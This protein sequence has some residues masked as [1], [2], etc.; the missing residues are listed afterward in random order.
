MSNAP[1]PKEAISY[2]RSVVD[3]VAGL[4]VWFC[5]L[6]AGLSIAWLLM[7]TSLRA[8]G[9]NWWWLAKMGTTELAYLCGAYALYLW[10][11]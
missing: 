6:I 7:S 9:H 4:I 5:L 10:K 2:L 1:N 8:L 3:Y 11:R